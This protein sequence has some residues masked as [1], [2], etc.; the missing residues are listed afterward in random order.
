MDLAFFLL[1]F[2]QHSL[3]HF[4]SPCKVYSMQQHL[5]FPSKF[6]DTAKLLRD[7][8][9]SFASDQGQNIYFESTFCMCQAIAWFW[10]CPPKVYMQFWSK[11]RKNCCL[12]R[13][14]QQGRM[15]ALVGVSSLMERSTGF[16]S[17]KFQREIRGIVKRTPYRWTACLWKTSC[18]QLPPKIKKLNEVNR[19]TLPANIQEMFK[20][21][22]EG[23]GLVE[24]TGDRWTIGPVDLRCLFQ[25]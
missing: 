11:A 18:S 16:V 5:L 9:H 22:T 7:V 23:C 24:N 21:C 17:Q 19:V 13:N 3:R 25:P 1:L 2:L 4:C 10:L 12:K 14:Q 8:S 6:W 20:H 15:S